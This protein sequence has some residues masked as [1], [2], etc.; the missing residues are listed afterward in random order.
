MCQEVY[1]MM[2]R[3]KDYEVRGWW[4]EI[5]DFMDKQ[6]IY[7]A[8]YIDEYAP[9]LFMYYIYDKVDGK[10]Y[11]EDLVYEKRS[12]M[13]TKVIKKVFEILEERSKE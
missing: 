9:P 7:M 11:K 1:D 5:T 10:E 6:G 3:V 13:E 8:Y 12:I 4:R 2:D